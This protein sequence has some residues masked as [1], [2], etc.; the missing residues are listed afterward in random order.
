MSHSLQKLLAAVR[1]SRRAVFYPGN[2]SRVFVNHVE[3]H[4]DGE[5]VEWTEVDTSCHGSACYER[6]PG[7]VRD[8]EN[9]KEWILK[10]LGEM[11]W[12]DFQAEETERRLQE[13]LK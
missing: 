11:A 1:A 6:T 9:L 8:A 3:Y 2:A 5:S 10:D 7:T 13:M 12:Q 4:I